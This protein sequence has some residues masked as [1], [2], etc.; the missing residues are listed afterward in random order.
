MGYG[1]TIVRL[2]NP[3]NVG[4]GHFS[5]LTGANLWIRC[6]AATAR[7]RCSTDKNVGPLTLGEASQARLSV[8]VLHCVSIARQ[9]C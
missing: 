4:T 6:L 5:G 2:P 1:S 9:R 7:W 8:C 3:T